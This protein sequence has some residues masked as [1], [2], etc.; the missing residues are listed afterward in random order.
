M[1]LQTSYR[2][3]KTTIWQH[4]SRPESWYHSFPQIMQS[5]HP[6]D[7]KNAFFEKSKKSTSKK[8]GGPGGK[9]PRQAEKVLKQIIFLMLG[10]DPPKNKNVASIDPAS[11]WHRF[12][13]DLA[14]IWYRSGIDSGTIGEHQGCFQDYQGHQK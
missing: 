9:A 11:I 2:Q 13:I 14:S 7:T 5:Y 6:N 12:G 8:L 3:K 4:F 10:G 1:G